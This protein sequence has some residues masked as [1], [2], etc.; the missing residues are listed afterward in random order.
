MNS[1]T[2]RTKILE[3]LNRTPNGEIGKRKFLFVGTRYVTYISLYSPSKL[4][5]MLLIDF[6]IL[7]IG[8]VAE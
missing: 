4:E 5:K 2:L 6:Y 3:L 8:G 1:K 7:Y